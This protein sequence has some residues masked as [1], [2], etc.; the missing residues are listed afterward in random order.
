[1]M[2]C[3][4][5]GVLL[6]S[7]AATGQ[8]S[9]KH[10]GLDTARRLRHQRYST[11]GP[12]KVNYEIPA[13]GYVTLVIEDKDGKRVRNLISDYPRLAGKNTDYWD[14]RDDDGRMLAPDTYRVRGLFHEAPDITYEFAFGTP[15]NRPWPSL[16]GRGGWLSNHT[17]QMAVLADE[18]RIYVAARKPRGPTR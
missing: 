17:N 10:A 15:T 18:D 4:V 2:R 14:G 12:V 16:D 11:T 1:M 7:S 3:L 8:E 13:D 6:W 5:L 9:N